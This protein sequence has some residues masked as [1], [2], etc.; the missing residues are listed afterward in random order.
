MLT[1]K[2]DSISTQSYD[3][4]AQSVKWALRLQNQ[5]LSYLFGPNLTSLRKMNLWSVPKTN[6]TIRR[7]LLRLVLNAEFKADVA[8]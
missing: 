5:L 7:K 8:T 1:Y 6:Y 3:V 2:Q 4:T